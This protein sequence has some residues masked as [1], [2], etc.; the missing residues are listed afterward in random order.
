[1]AGDWIKMRT[2]LYRDPK[3]CVIAD[4]LMA[5]D[6]DLARNVN[7]ICQR[8]MTVTRNVM[9]N[10]TVGALVTV[11]GVMR[12]RGKREGDDLVVRYGSLN[13]IDDLAEL[14]GFGDAM[15]RVGWVEATDDGIVFPRFFEDYNVDPNE[16]LKAK[17]AERQRRYREKAKASE[18]NVTS[19]ATVA[20]QSNAREEKRRVINPKAPSGA[21]DEFWNVYPKRVGRAAAEKAFAKVNPDQDLLAQI[22]AAVA[23]QSGSD[24]WRR[25]GG[26]FIPNPATW[27]NQARWLDQPVSGQSFKADDVFAGAK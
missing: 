23:A 27:L 10:V 14:P 5:P 19:N 21:F 20:S 6:G 24:Q 8:D 13:V 4:Y 7:Q 2:D 26:Q 16:D 15:Q 25:D 18:S 3:V 11:W 17:N 9:R 22:V 12:L 1:M